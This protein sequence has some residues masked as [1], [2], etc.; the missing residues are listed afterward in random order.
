MDFIKSAL[1]LTSDFSELIGDVDLNILEN[2]IQMSANFINYSIRL[3]DC[4]LAINK[5]LAIE[6]FEN[7]LRLID[8]LKR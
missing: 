8:L 3:Y 7:N 4:G 6:H 2:S 1:K 5:T